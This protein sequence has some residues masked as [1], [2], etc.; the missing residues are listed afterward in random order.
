MRLEVY[1]IKK[2]HRQFYLANYRHIRMFF[3]GV[4]YYE[5]GIVWK[6]IKEKP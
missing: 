2:Q 5:F 3:I 6:Q 4:Y 1:K